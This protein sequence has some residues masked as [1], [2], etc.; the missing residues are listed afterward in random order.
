[1]SLDFKIKYVKMVYNRDIKDS[2]YEPDKGISEDMINDVAIFP[3]FTIYESDDLIKGV[4]NGV[5][6]ISSDFNLKDEI[7][8]KYGTSYKSFFNGRLY[9]FDFNKKFKQ[10]LVLVQKKDIFGDRRPG[11]L[12]VYLYLTWYNVIN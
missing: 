2:K 1:M 12:Y 8:T 3:Y 11:N 6:Y 10:N 5:K 4:Y 7:K 9:Q